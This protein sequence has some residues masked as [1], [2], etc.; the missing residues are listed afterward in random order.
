MYPVSGGLMVEVILVMQV[1]AVMQR[2]CL[3]CAASERRSAVSVPLS[4]PSSLLGAR[5]R[6]LSRNKYKRVTASSAGVVGRGGRRSMMI[7]LV[8]RRR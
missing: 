6:S 4:G 3:A 5:F 7:N 2:P 1:D 8:K